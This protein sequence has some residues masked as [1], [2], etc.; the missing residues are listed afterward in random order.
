MSGESL[1]VEYKIHHY[2]Y[3]NFNSY[4]KVIRSALNELGHLE[5]DNPNVH[6]YNHCHKSELTTENNLIF[7]P[8][9]PSA[10]YFAIDRIGYAS[11]SE[12][13]FEEP[14]LP[15]FLQ[16]THLDNINNLIASKSNKWDNSILLKWR[17]PKNIPKDHILI[18]AQMPDDESVTR[19][20]FGD[21]IQK[22]KAIIEELKNENVILK[23]HPRYKPTDKLRKF[24][25]QYDIKIIEGYYS[26]HD[27]LTNTKVAIVENSTAGIECLMHNVPVI[28]YGWPEYHW[29]TYKLKSLTQLREL[30]NNLDWYDELYAKD[31]IQWYINSYL[32]CDKHSTMRRLTELG[33]GKNKG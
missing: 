33:Y 18:I 1:L 21:H 23:L 7:K 13:T 8:T 6:I 31:F 16:Y 3:D 15:G 14:N 9:A 32:C 19:H 17:K 2:R 22:I 28:S 12:L 5:S 4:E 29:A 24:C 25:K 30:V 20:S 11:A 10:N 26:I 27:I